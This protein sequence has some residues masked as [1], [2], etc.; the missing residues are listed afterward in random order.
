MA[1][2]L[3]AGCSG[4]DGKLPIPSGA[5]TTTTNANVYEQ[6]RADGVTALLDKLSTAL[7]T[8]DTKTL[9]GLIDA[10]ATPA[11]RTR[12]ETAAA[13]FGTRPP[14]ATSTTTR[15]S[16]PSPSA[17]PTQS[18]GPSSTEPDNPGRRGAGG[19]STSATPR[20][21]APKQSG[22]VSSTPARPMPDDSR[23]SAL[24][25]AKLRYQLVLSDEAETQAP[26]AITDKL[27]DQGSSDVWVAPVE[28]HYALGGARA[29]GVDE[30]E[31]VVNEQMVVARY[32]DDWKVVGDATLIGGNAPA[33]MLWELAG[34][35]VDDV[36][37]A[38]GTSVIASYPGTADTV[39]RARGLLPGAVRA[40]EAFWGVEWP[41]KV[42][43]VATGTGRQFT[44]VSG[45]PDA[46]GAAAA[47]TVFTGIDADKTVRGQRIVLTPNAQQIP[48]PALGV[49]LRHEITHVATRSI[50]SAKA[51]LWVTEGLAEYVGRKDTYRRLADAA[52]DLASAVRS[53][54]GPRTLPADADFAVSG[55]RAGLA[56]Q[57]AW[58]L[59]AFIA[60]RFGEDKLK[61]LYRK[62]AAGDAA[63]A[64]A[65]LSTELKITSGDL[66]TQW[67]RWLVKEAG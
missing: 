20:S 6:Q 57:S 62:A 31:L 3:L 12:L 59:W 67:R 29:P 9:A 61:S 35:R 4:D 53:G 40:V 45:A 21:T 48:P 13:N 46:D 34:L 27:T 14:R 38:G 50:T 64:D 15:S 36:P 2:A 37:T 43:V 19:T 47:A 65:A 5:A 16:A 17:G 39:E 28:L 60:T 52:P 1:S 24:R 63:V 54:S 25:L 23:G 18:P 41:R 55:P 11:F 32:E 22:P 56:Y 10:S 58:S 42:V 33:T 7:A 49:V 44:Q 30:P 66:V 51:P 8:G 26:E